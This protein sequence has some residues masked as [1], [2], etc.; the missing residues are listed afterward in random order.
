MIL[1]SFYPC[2]KNYKYNNNIYFELQL[3]NGTFTNPNTQSDEQR[4]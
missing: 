2:D 3:K 1:A 4:N